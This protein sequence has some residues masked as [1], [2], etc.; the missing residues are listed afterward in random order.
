[1]EAGLGAQAEFSPTVTLAPE[2]A[3]A[4]GVEAELWRRIASRRRE[5]VDG[6]KKIVFETRC[7]T[8]YFGQRSSWWIKDFRFLAASRT[9]ICFS[10]HALDNMVSLS[11]G[12]RKDSGSQF[13]SACNDHLQILLYKLS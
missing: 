4:P 11:R 9:G 1:V 2:V 6:Q 8:L 5:N 13:R 10:D 7:S 12:C 3:V